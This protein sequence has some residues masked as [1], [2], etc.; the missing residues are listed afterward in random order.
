MGDEGVYRWRIADVWLNARLLL[1]RLNP[2]LH[3]STLPAG[4][5]FSTGEVLIEGISFS[6]TIALAQPFGVRVLISFE[7][8]DYFEEAESSAFEV[9]F[10]VCHLGNT[11]GNLGVL[12]S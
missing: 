12:A 11:Y 2:P 5:L 6:A 3:S 7:E 8:A 1:F 4:L 9:L 10:W